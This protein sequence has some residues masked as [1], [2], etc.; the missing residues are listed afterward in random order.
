MNWKEGT[1]LVAAVLVFCA[2]VS[3][4]TIVSY[5]AYLEGQAVADCGPRLDVISGEHETIERS[6]VTTFSNLST[7]QQRA[8]EQAL[9]GESP[10]VDSSDW[11]HPYV[12]Y[13]NETYGTAI[14]VC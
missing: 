14:I 9:N 3:A 13:K 1:L 5:L 8:F 10:E 7:E 12:R 6:E 2:V 4:I 11:S